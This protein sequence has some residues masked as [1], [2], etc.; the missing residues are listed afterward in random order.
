M[1]K[2]L[3]TDQINLRLSKRGYTLV[4]QYVNVMTKSEFLCA[5]GHKWSATPDSVMRGS[6]CPFCSKAIYSQS[7]RMSISDVTAR[8]KTHGIEYVDGYRNCATPA[9]FKCEHGHIWQTSA[10]NVFAGRGCPVCANK[11]RGIA[12]RVTKS[13]INARLFERGIRLVNDVITVSTK[14]DF[15]CDCGNIW[16]AKPNNILN[17]TG[18]PKCAKSGFKVT[19][20]GVFYIIR[21]H[22]SDSAFVGYG[23]TNSIKTRLRRH[24][25]NIGNRGFTIDRVVEIHS[26]GVIVSSL[27][28]S[29]KR[30]F[31][32]FGQ[33][34]D[35]FA[36]EATFEYEFERLVGFA[37]SFVDLCS[38]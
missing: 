38:D 16:S 8:A 23:I 3:T 18:C 26:S 36:V 17:G 31:P 28:S 21:A 14:V 29:V 35:G 5:N 11:K 30:I 22:S 2:K 25:R 33:D 37:N 15:I 10:W 13:E 32:R 19:L 7:R 24:K 12:R 6:G 20:P 34:I 4:G 9:R 1:K 27:E